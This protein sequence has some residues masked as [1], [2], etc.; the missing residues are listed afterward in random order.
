M[1][2]LEQHNPTRRTFFVGFVLLAAVCAAVVVLRLK[3]PLPPG[4]DEFTR[5]MNV[6]KNYLDKGEADKAL[7]AFNQ[8]VALNPAH[9]DAQLNLA[10]ACLLAGQSE[11]AIQH[12]QEVLN[13]DHNS[14]AAHYVAGCANLRLARFEPAVQALQQSKDL[15][16]NVAAVSFQLGLAHLQLKHW[17][18]A[19]AEFQAAIALEPEHPAAHYNLSQ[20][21]I[22]AGRQDEANQELE[23]HRQLAAKSKTSLATAATYERCKHTQARTPFQL[24][25]P[26][27]DGVKV[28][29][30][31]QTQ[32]AFGSTAQ[33]YQG[34]I[35]VMDINHR[36]QNDLF[37]LERGKGFRLLLNT[38]GTFRPQGE[39]LPGLEGA[40]YSRCLVGDLQHDR[41]EDVIVLGNKGTHVFKFLTMAR[42]AISAP[43]PAG[44]ARGRRWGAGRSGFH[45][46][47]RFAGGDGRH[48]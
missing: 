25:Q 37:V 40:Q 16:P 24:E 36:G 10:N 21:L 46:Q 34:P 20:A 8:A 42:S 9:P 11:N 14:A 13:L 12:A 33:N 7:A 47:R 27:K 43:Y 35:G 45:R 32:A 44:L 48:E 2:A 15:D 38:N 23:T 30:V 29:F 1:S 22:R 26:L 5:V 18:D 4:E 31:D 28:V 41:Y 39:P 3:N 6:G 17:D 19:I